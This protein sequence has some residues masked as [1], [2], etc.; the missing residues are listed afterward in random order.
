MNDELPFALGYS[1]SLTEMVI[2][3]PYSDVPEESQAPLRQALKWTAL[4]F[5]ALAVSVLILIFV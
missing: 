2:R 5:V 4:S 3:G 1:S